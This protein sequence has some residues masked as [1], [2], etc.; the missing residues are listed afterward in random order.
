M[1]CRVPKICFPVETNSK[2]LKTPSSMEL[3]QQI[4]DKKSQLKIV[5]GFI[6]KQSKK[7]EKY[8][9]KFD[10]KKNNYIELMNKLDP[11][12]NN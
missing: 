7:R 5:E 10:K 3:M 4:E 2:M 6:I 8:L 12:L 11:V 9:K 1:S